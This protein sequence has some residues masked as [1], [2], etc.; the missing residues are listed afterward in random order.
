MLEPFWI[1]GAILCNDV[2]VGAILCNDVE[3]IIVIIIVTFK[4]HIYKFNQLRF[5]MN[6]LIK[7]EIKKRYSRKK[8]FFKKGLVLSPYSSLNR[9]HFK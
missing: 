2:I 3:Q 4:N 9:A 7:N 1:V 5:D 8:A 6:N